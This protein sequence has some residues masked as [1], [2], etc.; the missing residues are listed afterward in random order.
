ML[1]DYDTA[2]YTPNFGNETWTVLRYLGTLEPATA[3]GSAYVVCDHPYKINV[4]YDQTG[5]NH[6]KLLPTNLHRECQSHTQFIPF[7]YP[8]FSVSLSKLIGPLYYKLHLLCTV[9][10]SH[11]KFQQ[12]M[13]IF[14]LYREFSFK[15]QKRSNYNECL[16]H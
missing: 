13:T 11:I 4:A 2:V 16:Y 1:P 6:S 3:W 14:Q 12:T 15:N 9:G 8:V 10:K 5:F 7:Y